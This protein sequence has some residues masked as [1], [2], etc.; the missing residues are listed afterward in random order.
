MSQKSSLTQP[1]PVSGALTAD[2]AR[3]FMLFPKGKL[4]TRV[5]MLEEKPTI[6]RLREAV[7]LVTP[8]DRMFCSDFHDTISCDFRSSYLS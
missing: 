8:V 2:S 6:N 7:L 1:A 5:T 4:F 3:V